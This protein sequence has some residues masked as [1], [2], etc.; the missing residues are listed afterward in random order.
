MSESGRDGMNDRVEL[1]IVSDLPEVHV[2]CIT[3]AELPLGLAPD[4]WLSETGQSPFPPG[5]SFGEGL[6]QSIMKTAG[7]RVH[8]EHKHV[9]GSGCGHTAVKHDGHL[10][11]LHDGHLHHADNGMVSEHEVAGSRDNPAGCTPGHECGSHDSQHVHGAG[12]GHE[13][14]PHAGHV[15]YLVGDHLHHAHAGH[16]D[17]HGKLQISKPM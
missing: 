6:Q 17:D 4:S 9:H 5:V 3:R 16:C 14:V 2:S 10:D 7:S 12:C 15:D 11:Y 1:W 8:G 13:A